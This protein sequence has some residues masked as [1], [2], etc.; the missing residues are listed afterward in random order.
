M[1]TYSVIVLLLDD[2]LTSSISLPL[3]M[4]HAAE[5]RRK[6][7]AP[8]SPNALHIK[9]VALS[10][11]IIRTTAGLTIVP[12]ALYEDIN[13]ADLVLIPSIWR[14]PLRTISDQPRLLDWL[15]RLHNNGTQLCAVSTGA[16]LLAEAGLLDQRP[17]TTHWFYLDLFEQRYPNCNLQRHHLITQ[18]DGLHCAGSVNAAADLMIYFVKVTFGQAISR[19]V[20]SQFSPEIRR[21]YGESLYIEQ[22]LQQHPD[23][24]VAQVQHSINLD[25]AT[26]KSIAGL[27]Q[28]HGLSVRTLNRRFK[29]VTGITPLSYLQQKKLE[30]ARELLQ[31]S[32]LSIA[33]IADQ[34]GFTDISYFGAQF[35]KHMAITPRQ[36]RNSVR[37]KLFS[38]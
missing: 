37:G 36:Y 8:R 1:R 28:Q 6:I 9:T 31:H 16:F 5:N 3:E 19:Q 18:K 15:R 12:D 27:A 11:D 2:M 4:L 13:H 26:I 22:G 35:K 30:N 7:K 10:H 25:S 24:E 34:T 21:S 29:H 38:A 20:E 23:E 32:N 33:D 14:N 17:A